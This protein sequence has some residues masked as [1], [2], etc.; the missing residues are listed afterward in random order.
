MSGSVLW[1]TLAD[2][3][4]QHKGQLTKSLIDILLV[5]WERQIQKRRQLGDH[6][7]TEFSCNPYTIHWEAVAEPVLALAEAPVAPGTD[8]TLEG[9]CR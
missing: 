8:T 5:A 4:I 1:H 7:S 3:K 6:S 2:L 9:T